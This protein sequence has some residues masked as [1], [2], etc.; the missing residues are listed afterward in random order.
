[1]TNMKKLL[2]AAAALIVLSVPAQ[3]GT[4]NDWLGYCNGNKGGSK[5]SQFTYCY[6]Y[7]RAVADTAM[8]WAQLATARSAFRRK[9]PPT[10]SWQ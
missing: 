8:L 7:T 9:Q 10:S 2:T 3:A 6:A 4:V 5:D 1:M